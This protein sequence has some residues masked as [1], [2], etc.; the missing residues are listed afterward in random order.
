MDSMDRAD[1]LLSIIER[2]VGH[3]PMLIAIQAAAMEEL[4][5]METELAEARDEAAKAAARPKAVPVVAEEP[6]EERRV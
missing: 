5:A 2:C 3:G 4:T 6:V 1:L